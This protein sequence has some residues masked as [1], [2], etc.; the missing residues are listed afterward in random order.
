M[1]EWLP[2]FLRV[3][4]INGYGAIS[5]SGAGGLASSVGVIPPDG[6]KYDISGIDG[7]GFVLYFGDDIS[8]NVNMEVNAQIHD[9]HTIVIS[10][11]SKDGTY[12]VKIW[13][14]NW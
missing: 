1:S 11:A 6:A 13:F 7:D 5:V 3:E 9:T 2:K 8:G 4:V 14:G 12:K 10:D